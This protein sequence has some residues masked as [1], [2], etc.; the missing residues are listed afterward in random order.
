[1]ITV[2]GNDAGCTNCKAATS[3]MKMYDVAITKIEA[4]SEEGQQLLGDAG[5]RTIPAFFINGK[6]LGDYSWF[7]SSGLKGMRSGEIV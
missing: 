5:V 6:Y 4:F 7:L 1:M 2:V 3:A